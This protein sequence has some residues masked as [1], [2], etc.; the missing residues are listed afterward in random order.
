ME[1]MKRGGKGRLLDKVAVTT[2]ING[3]VSKGKVKEAMGVFELR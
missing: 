1:D 3:L 2:V